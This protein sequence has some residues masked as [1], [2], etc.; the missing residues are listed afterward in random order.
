M[1][2]DY[3]NELNKIT[4]VSRETFSRLEQF[5]ELLLKWNRK[6]NLIGKSTADDVWQRHIIDSAQ[7][8]KYIP[9]NSKI[10]TDFGSGA[11]FPGMVLAIL[12]D[13]EVHLV[14]SDQ[15]KCAFLLEASRLAGEKVNVHNQRIE[16]LEPWQSD[17]IT[18][19]ALASLDKLLSLTQKFVEKSKLSLFLKGQNVVEEIEEASKSWNIEYK[20]FPSMTSSNSYILA[21]EKINQPGRV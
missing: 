9:S 16:Q 1:S 10:V 13:F 12:A 19:R 14:E 5:V 7:L 18:A 3:F 15:R 8:L 4:T 6:I 17:I 2:Q 20:I 11:G 21:V